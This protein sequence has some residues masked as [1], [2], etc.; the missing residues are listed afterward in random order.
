[1]VDDDANRVL[2]KAALY[3]QLAA[4][5]TDAQAMEALRAMALD[6]RVRAGQLFAVA[7][8]ATA[9]AAIPSAASLGSPERRTAACLA[10]SRVQADC[11]GFCRPVMITSTMSIRQ[12]TDSA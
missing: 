12:N 8:V 10:K 7:V 9:S 1:M 3:E 6:Y 4:R 5:N 11:K 2:Q